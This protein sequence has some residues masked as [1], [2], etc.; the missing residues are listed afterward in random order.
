LKKTANRFLI[1]L[2]IGDFGKKILPFSKP[3]NYFSMKRLLLLLA[4]MATT[5][6]YAQRNCGS[7]EYLQQQL[8]ADPEIQQNMNEIE[9]LT[10]KYVQT[11][12]K[13]ANAVISIPVVVHVV[14]NRRSASQNISNAQI[15]SQIA[16]L[17]QDFRRLNSDANNTWPQAADSEIEFCLASIDPSGNTTSGITRKRSN[18]SSFSYSNDGVKFSSS[19]GTNAWPTSDYLNIWVCNLGSGLLGYAQFPGGGASTD[20]VV[21]DYAY[22]G[23]TG[24][25]TAPF[26]LGRT[27]THEVGHWLNL[28]HIWGDGGCGVDDFCG[29]TPESDA[30]NYNCATG[31]VS[32]LTADMVE[33][34]MDYS[35]DACMNLFTTDQKD[36]MNALFQPNGFRAGL[37]S[38]N[39]C[40]TGGPPVATCTDNIQNGQ[41]TGID[42]GGPDC[43]DCP[44][45]SCDAPTN[46]S[47]TP[48]RGGKAAKLDWSA[49]AGASNYT[50][51]LKASSSSN[52]QSFSASSNTIQITGL[53]KGTS[54]DWRVRTNCGSTNSAFA[55]QTFIAG[56]SARLNSEQVL[57]AYPNPSSDLLYIEYSSSNEN[58][59]YFSL[60]SLDGK[61]VLN[62]TYSPNLGMNALE[63]DV[64]T[65]KT[66]IYILQIQTG[67]GIQ[68]KRI[69][70]IH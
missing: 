10:Q 34:Y 42:C 4:F 28:R 7:T 20:G 31:H 69:S 19:G 61:R 70:V 39:G 66:G 41:E 58:E 26:D 44:T 51:E 60:V 35:D 36:R 56:Q 3:K 17:N 53:I 54:Y 62:L 55:S 67:N 49:I 14:Y 32:C 22:F 21:V 5:L 33:N 18:K 30:P 27:T 47:S 68:T 2:I 59:N 43:P 63:L 1:N 37:L 29:D 48:K 9:R 65:L 8:N 11:Q 24:T 13:S 50:V 45:T 25:A 57:L 12:F 23:N 6:T 52:W 38:S 40:G 16:I 46:L 64:S 15:A